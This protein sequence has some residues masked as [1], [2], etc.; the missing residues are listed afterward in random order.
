MRAGEL[1]YSYLFCSR[2][3]K[4][5]DPFTQESLFEEK[6]CCSLCKDNWQ[7]LFGWH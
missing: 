6:V 3:G 7:E 1:F 5:V 2:C 4:S